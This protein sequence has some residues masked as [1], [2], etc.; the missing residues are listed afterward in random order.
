MFARICSWLV[1]LSRSAASAPASVM[2]SGTPAGRAGHP[3]AVAAAAVYLASDDARFVHGTV[4]DVDGGRTGVAVIAAQS[5]LSGPISMRHPGRRISPRSLSRSLS[6]GVS[7]W[8][9][10]DGTGAWGRSSIIANTA[11]YMYRG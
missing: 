1:L 9:D 3:D 6:G 8:R 7:E 4:L 10:A 11:I 5:W 2:M